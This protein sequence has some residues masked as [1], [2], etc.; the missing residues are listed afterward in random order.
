MRD[1]SSSPDTMRETLGVRN[2]LAGR[3]TAWVQFM[4][5]LAAVVAL[6]G[7]AWLLGLSLSVA[8]LLLVGLAGIWIVLADRF[9]R[10]LGGVPVLTW[11]SVSEDTAWLPWADQIAVSPAT[12][13]RQLAVLSKMKMQ[14]ID[15]VD[16]LKLRLAG[17][18]MPSDVVVLHFDDGYLDNWVAAAAIL[19]RHRMCATVFVS[20]DFIAAD[21]PLRPSTAQPASTLQWQGYMNWSELAALENG[22]FG[23]VFRVEP[24]G[25][26][27]ARIV[28]GPK[29]VGRLTAANWRRLVWVQWAK[30]PGDKHRWFTHSTPWAVP[31]GSAVHESDGALAAPGWTES[32]GR[33]SQHDYVA[34]VQRDLAA[35]RTAFAERLGK[36]PRVFCWPQNLT[37][38]LARDIAVQE[39]FWGTTGGRG[40]NRLEEDPSVISRLHVGARC[41]GFYWPWA[42]DLALRASIRCFQGN[43]YWYLPLAALGALKAVT[44]RFAPQVGPR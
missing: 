18:T 33:E 12:L 8:G 9:M 24:H 26:D 25:V 6:A 30:T 42:D 16:F 31:L 23:G 7:F 43:Q 22:A 3:R 19:Q 21:G 14:V 1:F 44:R 15:T 5:G 27:H 40:A 4:F 11:H 28:T 38:P 17:A 2:R 29:V 13:N 39:G 37:S 35:C 36:Q 32:K 34:R 10:D 20:L 41:A